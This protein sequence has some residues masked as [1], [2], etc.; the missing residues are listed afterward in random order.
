MS[1]AETFLNNYEG[2]TVDVA[3]RDITK[4]YG[5]LSKKQVWHPHFRTCSL[6]EAYVLY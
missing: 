6:S 4:L 2:K 5:A 3:V 1:Q